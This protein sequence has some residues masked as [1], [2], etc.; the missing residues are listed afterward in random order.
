MIKKGYALTGA[1]IQD[2][3]PTILYAMGLPLA[4]DMDGRVLAEAFT[5]PFTAEHPLTFS[6]NAEQPPQH[7]DY[8][9]EEARQVEERLREL[10]YLG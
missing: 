5:Y 9:D 7:A 4:R 1:Q 6:D 2:M 3:T 10:G 8:T